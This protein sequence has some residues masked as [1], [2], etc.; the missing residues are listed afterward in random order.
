MAQR[1]AIVNELK[2]TLRERGI[3][4]EQVRPSHEAESREREAPVRQ[5]QL[6]LERID[7]VCEFLTAHR[8]AG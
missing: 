8:A 3:T 5:R 1:T 7:A 6:H 2:R 4:Y